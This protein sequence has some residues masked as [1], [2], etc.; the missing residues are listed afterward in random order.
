VDC[1]TELLFILVG[2][3]G[4]EGQGSDQEKEGDGPVKVGLVGREWD[5]EKGGAGGKVRA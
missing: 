4:G 3:R 2:G 5:G 1:L